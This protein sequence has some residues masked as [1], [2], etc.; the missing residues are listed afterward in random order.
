M[1]KNLWTREELIVAL[2]LYLKLPFGKL[3]SRTNEIIDL[4]NLI[5]RTPGAVAMRLNNFASVDPYH[6]KRGIKGL[7]GGKK[8][9]KPIWDEFIEHKEEL[10][11]ESEKLLAVFEKTTIEKKYD[12]IL[13]DLR[14]L[15]GE[16]KK[17]IVKTRINQNVFRKI[18]LNNYKRKCTITG[19]NVDK[20]L[21]ASHILPWAKYKKERLNP[22]NG[23]CLNALHDKAFDKGLLT[24]TPE[25]KIRISGLLLGKCKSNDHFFLP[26]QNKNIIKPYKFLP[27]KEFLE[28]H[29]NNVF[30]ES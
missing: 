12:F 11:F 15:K 21:V 22:Q 23:I 24:I 16:T 29:N 17:R 26:Y 8:Q 27:N 19:I 28:Y 4:A 5:D 9:V 7:E 2:N 14:E 1:Q 13:Y 3:H 6:Q 25:Y 20:I 30:L 10:I 18:V